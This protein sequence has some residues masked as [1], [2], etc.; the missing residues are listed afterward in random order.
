MLNSPHEFLKECTY[1]RAEF[2]ASGWRNDIEFE[3][4]RIDHRFCATR[5]T[6]RVGEIDSHAMLEPEV[7]GQLWDETFHFLKNLNRVGEI[8]ADVSFA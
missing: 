7:W 5:R 3:V 8:L 6:R 2:M 4:R 1:G